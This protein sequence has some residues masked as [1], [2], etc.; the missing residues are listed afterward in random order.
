MIILGIGGGSASGKTTIT[1]QLVDGLGDRAALLSHDRYYRPLPPAFHDHP[2]TYNFDEPAALESSL[3]ATHLHALR[4]GERIDVPHYDYA[5]HDRSGSE[6]MDPA[7]IVVVEGILVLAEHAL[8]DAFDL[9]VFVA[10]PDAV[11][12]ERRTQRDV[13]ERGRSRESVLEQYENTVRPM[14]DKWVAPC[15]ALADLV[16]D[17]TTDVS[18]N[19]RRILE[20]LDRV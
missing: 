12:L 2:E 17:G 3:L 20:R 13:V 5:S 8:R 10:C 1:Q 19:V 6:S 4:R 16:L 14:H 15:E 11:R 18:G 7:E 9:S